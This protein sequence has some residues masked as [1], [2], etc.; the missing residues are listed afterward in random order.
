MEVSNY[1]LSSW[2]KEKRDN[3]RIM[4]D[5]VLSILSEINNYFDEHKLKL[6]HEDDSILLIQLIYFLYCNSSHQ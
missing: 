3:K 2:L 5:D 4:F 1:T 6:V